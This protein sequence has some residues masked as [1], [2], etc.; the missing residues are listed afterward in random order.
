MKDLP[1]HRDHQRDAAKHQLIK[2]SQGDGDGTPREPTKMSRRNK[3]V[4]GFMLGS[5]TYAVTSC[6]YENRL[7][8]SKVA[9]RQAKQWNFI[10]MP[11]VKEP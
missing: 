6:F 10:N 4:I 7:H 5:I 11:E 9:R 3:F 1:E 2:H 8:E